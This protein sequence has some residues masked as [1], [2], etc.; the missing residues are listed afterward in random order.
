MGYWSISSSNFLRYGKY[1][2]NLLSF[3]MFG[4]I[5]FCSEYDSV[6]AGFCF[7][8]NSCCL[9]DTRLLLQRVLILHGFGTF[10]PLISLVPS[11]I[12]ILL[13]LSLDI[14]VDRGL[15]S[16][17]DPPYLSLFLCVFSFS[18]YS[19]FWN[20]PN[21]MLSMLLWQSCSCF[22]EYCVFS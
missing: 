7:C 13:S 9:M 20:L 11:S 16:W 12:F 8:F 19:A 22:Q 21:F 4:M 1:K 18:F 5:W 17:T 15:N 14:L 2:V 10:C 3:C 6:L